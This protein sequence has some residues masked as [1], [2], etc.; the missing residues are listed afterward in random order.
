ML[1]I[2]RILRTGA[3]R[4]LPDELTEGL[5]PVTFSRSANHPAP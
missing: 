2:A 3:R 1:V 5:A 4:L